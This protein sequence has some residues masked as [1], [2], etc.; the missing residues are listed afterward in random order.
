MKLKKSEA[1]A[2]GGSRASENK[3]KDDY[4][5]EKYVSHS[6]DEKHVQHFGRKN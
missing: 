2:Q 6:A 1:R 4:M 3:I 5:D